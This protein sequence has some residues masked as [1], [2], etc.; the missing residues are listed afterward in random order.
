MSLLKWFFGID[1]FLHLGFWGMPL[2]FYFLPVSLIE[3]FLYSLFIAFRGENGNR[4]RPMLAGTA[5]LATLASICAPLAIAWLEGEAPRFPELS[6]ALIWVLW[7]W[8]FVLVPQI[9]IRAI[10]KRIGEKGWPDRSAKAILWRFVL[11]LILPVIL[12][13]VHALAGGLIG[14]TPD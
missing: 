7:T 2:L 13:F 4:N 3:N 5:I 10:R 6:Y 8:Y 11:T 9:L 1:G 14:V 12:C